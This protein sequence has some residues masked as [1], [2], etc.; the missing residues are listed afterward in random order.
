MNPLNWLI[1]FLT[2][3]RCRI[4]RRYIRLSIVSGDICSF[5]CLNM[6]MDLEKLK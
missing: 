1:G 5:K 3:T 4:C 2:N 6:E